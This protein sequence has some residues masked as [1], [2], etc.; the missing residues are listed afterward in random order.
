ME[1]LIFKTGQNYIILIHWILA[2]RF[3]LFTWV[4][5]GTNGDFR[6]FLAGFD[7]DSR[8]QNMFNLGLDYTMPEMT[9]YLSIETGFL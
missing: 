3:F 5:L 2:S 9:V 8:E 6:E 1:W 4:K 7:L